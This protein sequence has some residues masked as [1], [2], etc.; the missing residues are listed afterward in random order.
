[1]FRWLVVLAAVVFLVIGVVLYFAGLALI[2]PFVLMALLVVGACIIWWPPGAA[3]HA[4]AGKVL[5]FF[6]VP[7]T[8][9]GAMMELAWRHHEAAFGLE[10]V[11]DE[12]QAKMTGPASIEL[13]PIRFRTAIA[14]G[15]GLHL[16]V[17]LF[18]INAD[19]TSDADLATVTDKDKALVIGPLKPAVA[20]E[21]PFVAVTVEDRDA[22]PDVTVELAKPDGPESSGEVRIGWDRKLGARQALK[23][24]GRPLLQLSLQGQD[25]TLEVRNCTVAFGTYER[26]L[27]GDTTLKIR[28]QVPHRAAP[29]ILSFE[30]TTKEFS[31]VNLNLGVDKDPTQRKD[32]ML[33]AIKLTGAVRDPVLTRILKGQLTIQGISPVSIKAD[34]AAEPSISV[35]GSATMDACELQDDGLHIHATGKATA[36]TADNENRMPSE[37]TKLLQSSVV[38]A[39]LAIIAWLIDK[40]FNLHDVLMKNGRSTKVT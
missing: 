21:L 5:L 11:C 22:A 13:H 31:E 4:H 17:A 12:F 14:E 29:V 18:V 7:A 35:V 40:I 2:T 3:W 25:Y 38:L 34:T 1:M 8:V 36:V 32:P 23:V 16:K 20:D 27:R 24:A 9:L 19:G 33:A 6:L 28:G 37:L 15:P 30:P 10:A 39:F 26:D